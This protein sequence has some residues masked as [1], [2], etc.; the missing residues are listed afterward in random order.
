MTAQY[1]RGFSVDTLEN[2]REFY[3]SYRDRIS[4]TAFRIF[5]KDIV[6]AIL[7]LTKDN[8]IR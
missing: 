8:M 6:L 5:V 3:L 4:E 7:N 1:G 2:M